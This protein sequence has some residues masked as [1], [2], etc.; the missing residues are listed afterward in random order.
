MCRL[1]AH[2]L[3]VVKK[4]FFQTILNFVLSSKTLNTYNDIARKHGNVAVKDLGKYEKLRYK[5][6][7]LKLDIDFFNN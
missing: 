7:K 5:N 3:N 1:K 2:C 4:C 6:N